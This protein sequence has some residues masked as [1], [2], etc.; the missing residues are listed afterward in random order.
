MNNCL[1]ISWKFDYDTN[2]VSILVGTRRVFHGLNKGSGTFDMRLTK[3]PVSSIVTYRNPAELFLGICKA[4]T[5]AGFQIEMDLP[6]GET[7]D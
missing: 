1:T 3:I 4:Y 2:M 7:L 6:K 5:D